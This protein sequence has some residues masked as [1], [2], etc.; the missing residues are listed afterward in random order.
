MISKSKISLVVVSVLLICLVLSTD[1]QTVEASVLRKEGGYTVGSHEITESYAYN[2]DLPDSLIGKWICN[3]GIRYFDT[4]EEADA[5]AAAFDA[6][7]ISNIGSQVNYYDYLAHNVKKE[8]SVGQYI[9]YYEDGYFVTFPSYDEAIYAYN[10]RCELV[11]QSKE[12]KKYLASL[13]NYTYDEENTLRY[14][15]SMYLD[16]NNITYNIDCVGWTFYNLQYRYLQNTSYSCVIVYNANNNYGDKKVD[17][18][19]SYM[20]ENVYTEDEI[21]TSEGTGVYIVKAYYPQWL[22]GGIYY[23][24]D[25]V[26][27]G[28]YTTLNEAM[29]VSYVHEYTQIYTCY[30]YGGEKTYGDMELITILYELY[31]LGYDIT[32]LPGYVG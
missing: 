32:T 29:Q 4:E 11:E 3:P 9:G 25:G 7:T 15:D 23:S 30:A 6:G 8:S 17:N 31:V 2:H 13:F 1:M 26:D 5:Y 22:P 28:P 18:G 12:T 20:A 27:L 19:I 16:V 24:E 21:I 10:Y 14:D